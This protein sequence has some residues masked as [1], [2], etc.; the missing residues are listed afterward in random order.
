MSED[1]NIRVVVAIDFGT[2]FSGYAYAHKS[3]P[4]EIIFRNDWEK[5]GG[6]FKTP[7]VIEYK[8]DSYTTIKSWGYLALIEKPK[9]KKKSSSSESDGSSDTKRTFKPIEL[10]KLHSLESLKEK[11]K[12]F[13][14]DG[15][16]FKNIV[17]DFMKE[18]GDDIKEN[19]IRHWQNL[20]FHN[21]VLIVL[22]VPAEFDDKTIEI[23]RECA[24]NAG[25][26]KDNL[27]ITTEPEAAAIYYLDS[28]SKEEHELT[29]ASFMV[30]DCGDNTVDL[31][32]FELLED[33]KLSALE[34][35][36]GDYCGSC[37]VDQAFLKFVGEIVGT[38]AIESMK[39]NHHGQLQY[40]VQEFCRDVKIPFT[41]KK[42]DLDLQQPFV[43]DL[44]EILP[45]IQQYVK[46][47]ERSK[48]E[49]SEWLIEINFEDIKGMFDPVIEKIIHLIRSQLDKSEKECPAI[50]LVG[51]FS[52][53]KYLQ[54]II[55]E[56]FD[57]IVPNISVPLHPITSVVK[58]GKTVFYTDSENKEVDQRTYLRQEGRDDFRDFQ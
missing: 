42:E 36:V 39:I 43:F 55:R 7:T 15:L 35:H 21:N 50:F 9:K 17:K 19:L 45:A 29:P 3:L 31:M 30:V 28:I 11:E 20:D 58:G 5:F 34:E 12:P 26:L 41:G 48:L 16:D 18:L 44:E 10:F 52:E 38:S 24:F 37:C 13:L 27:R 1:N 8:D 33:E 32:T 4:E 49:E 53:S 47:E 23:F 40:F 6:R 56:E 54:D 22:T 14:P 25:F 51:G 57:E 2:N 46:E